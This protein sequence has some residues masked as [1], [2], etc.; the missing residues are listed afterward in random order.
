MDRNQNKN[1]KRFFFSRK[2]AEWGRSTSW[3][4]NQ[5]IDLYLLRMKNINAKVKAKEANKKKE[6]G[7]RTCSRVRV[8]PHECEKLTSKRHSSRKCG[9]FPLKI[10]KYVMEFWPRHSAFNILERRRRHRAPCTARHL[11]T[12]F[13]LCERC[14]IDFMRL[15]DAELF[16]SESTI[17]K[18]FAS[19]TGMK[20]RRHISLAAFHKYG[21]LANDT[22]QFNHIS[23]WPFPR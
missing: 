13:A 20:C 21:A 22:C 9:I 8:V 1:K 4:K 5:N 11:I 6:G 3:W 19:E 23:R 7:Q 18:E 17:A 14:A 10:F 2:W 16:E 15:I 12:I